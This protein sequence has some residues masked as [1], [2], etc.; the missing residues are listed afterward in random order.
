MQHHRDALVAMALGFVLTSAAMLPPIIADQTER[1]A[2]I[3]AF[4]ET[5]GTE[6]VTFGRERTG[7]LAHLIRNPEASRSAGV[8]YAERTQFSHKER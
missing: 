2:R 7:R 6:S 5:T 3:A 1:S 4:E 8:A